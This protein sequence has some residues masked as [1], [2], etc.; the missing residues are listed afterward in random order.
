T[1]AYDAAIAGW[2]AGQLG[3]SFPAELTL[4]GRRGE[5][6]RYGENPH[7]QAAFY[8]TGEARPGVATARQLQGKQLSYNN[9]NDTDAAFEAVAEFER[10]AVVIVKHANPCGVA[11]AESLEVA[12]QRALACDPVSAFGGIVAVNRRLD[13]PTAARIAELFAE[14]VIAPEI[15]AEAAALLSAKKNLRVLETGAVPDPAAAGWT[16]KSLADGFLLQGRD[17]GRI[18]RD[19]LKV[20]TKRAPSEAELEDLI[21]AF[22]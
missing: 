20:V 12:Y 3:E 6:L 11:E 16:F 18:A 10:P 15:S 8:R 7:Q 22:R 13:E 4:A 19:R 17:D 1:A 14:V 2:F 9:L 5:P 21:F